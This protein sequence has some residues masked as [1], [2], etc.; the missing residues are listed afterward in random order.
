M[1][2]N[3][4][5]TNWTRLVFSVN[6]LTKKLVCLFLKP[7]WYSRVKSRR[8]LQILLA[9]W[10]APPGKRPFAASQSFWTG[11]K[12]STGFSSCGNPAI[13]WRARAV[14]GILVLL[15]RS[16]GKKPAG[17]VAWRRG[18]VPTQLTVEGITTRRRGGQGLRVISP[19]EGTYEGDEGGG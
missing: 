3:S 6:E 2:S 5:R 7:G 13:V 17:K 4:T 15:L 10:Q 9:H 18:D 16:R 8:N 11:Q 1:N 12:R 14:G 19:L